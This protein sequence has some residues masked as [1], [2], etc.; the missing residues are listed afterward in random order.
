MLSAI[1]LAL[2]A[3]CAATGETVASGPASEARCTEIEPKLDQPVMWSMLD[4]SSVP[5]T[6]LRSAVADTL[7][8]RARYDSTGTLTSFDAHTRPGK[9]ARAEAAT[10]ALRSFVATTSAAPAISVSGLLVPGS[11]PHFAPV[12]LSYECA[13]RLLN[14]SYIALRLEQLAR[15]S[16]MSGGTVTLRL[17]VD[18]EGRTTDVRLTRSSG[19]ATQDNSVIRVARAARFTPALL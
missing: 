4:L 13:P 19:Q 3:G 18:E 1:C 9:R 12:Q 17:K 5:P 16:T 15:D 6:I 7:L 2:V 8:L 10:L 11:S 14:T